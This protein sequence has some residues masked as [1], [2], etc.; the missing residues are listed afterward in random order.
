MRAPRSGRKFDSGTALYTAFRTLDLIW[1]IGLQCR[2]KKVWN[3]AGSGVM[4]WRD[5][6]RAGE[7]SLCGERCGGRGLRVFAVRIPAASDL[8]GIYEDVGAVLITLG[9]SSVP[10]FRFATSV[11]DGAA[12]RAIRTPPAIISSN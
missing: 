6:L 4:C 1:R 3:V 2:N 11:S 12:I 10:S 5:T 9:T 8:V 7:G